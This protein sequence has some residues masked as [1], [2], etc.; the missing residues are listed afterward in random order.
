MSIAHFK[1]FGRIL[2]K[3]GLAAAMDFDEQVTQKRKTIPAAIALGLQRAHCEVIDEIAT[4]KLI[5]VPQDPQNASILRFFAI[6]VPKSAAKIY[7]MPFY[8]SAKQMVLAGKYIAE[9][10]RKPN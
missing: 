5:D 6:E 10:Y 4:I 2:R 1:E 7:F 3:D 9:E 8:L